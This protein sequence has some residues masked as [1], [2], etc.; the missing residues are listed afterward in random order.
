MRK[1]AFKILLFTLIL[2]SVFLVN[3]IAFRSD[4]PKLWFVTLI[5]SVIGFI[6]FPYN[7]FFNNNKNK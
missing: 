4:L 6:F 2:L 5:G 7:Q 3:M 1:T